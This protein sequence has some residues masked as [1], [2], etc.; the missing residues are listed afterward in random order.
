MNFLYEPLAALKVF[1]K[2]TNLS[3]CENL[4]YLDREYVNEMT[5]L[6]KPQFISNRN[7]KFMKALKHTD[8]F[9]LTRIVEF[10]VGVSYQIDW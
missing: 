8:L 10:K 4:C 5:A 3:T 1:W 6:I 7:L 2:Q 9:E